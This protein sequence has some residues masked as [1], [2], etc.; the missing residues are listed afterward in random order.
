MNFIETLHAI[1]SDNRRARRRIWSSR[2]FVGM[3]NGVLCI[4]G[5]SSTGPDDGL[6]HPWTVTES[7]YFA[8]DWEV[9]E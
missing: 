4:K 8:D 1:F 7:D 6:W 9:I 5:F 3:E 2:I